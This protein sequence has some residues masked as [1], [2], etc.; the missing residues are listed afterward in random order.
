MI[1]T[2]EYR[3]L[4]TL[5]AALGANPLRTQGAGGNTSL[6]HDGTLWIKA[7]GA[8]LAHAE[9]RDIM[10]PVHLRPL[11]D[12]LEARDP[13]GE[14]AMDF[15][16]QTHNPGALRPSIETS[17]HALIPHAVVAHFHCVETIALAV[18]KDCAALV[19]PLL[20]PLPDVHWV[21]IPYRRPGLPLARAIA[22]RIQPDTNVLILGNHGLVVAGADVAETADRIERVCT[23]LKTVPRAP[24]PADLGELERL[25]AQTDYRLPQHTRLHSLALDPLN[26][27]I[28]QGGSLYPDHV[29]FLGPGVV[30]APDIAAGSTMRQPG[31]RDEPPTLLSLP[32]TGVVLHRTAKPSAEMMALCLLDV[33]QRVPAG[34]DLLRLSADDEYELTHWDAERYRQALDKPRQTESGP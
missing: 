20:A 7:S 27:A 5:S 15:V 19:A 14:A 10:V 13:R 34:A 21:H 11:L 30:S 3:T 26:R 16:D 28:V 17:V 18:R 32:G 33:A 25:A 24:Q 12:A 6:K 2:A 31:W 29:I 9:E 23:A 1:E 8:W 22:E 4:R